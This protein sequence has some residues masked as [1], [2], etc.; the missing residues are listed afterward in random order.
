MQL[1]FAVCT[2]AFGAVTIQ[3]RLALK[4]SDASCSHNIMEAAVACSLLQ[5]LDGVVSAHS[6]TMLADY[7]ITTTMGAGHM[8]LHQYITTTQWDRR[9][10]NLWFVLQSVV[11][12]IAN[13]HSLCLAHLDLKAQNIIITV[14]GHTITSA[15]L[16]D[17]GSARFVGRSDEQPAHVRCTYHVAAPESLQPSATPSLSCDMYSLGALMHFYINKEHVINCKDVTCKKEA[18]LR[19]N[20]QGITVLPRRDNCP[21][22]LYNI[23]CWL[24][25]PDPTLRPSIQGM[26]IALCWVECACAS[27][28]MCCFPAELYKIFFTDPISLNYTIFTPRHDL[29]QQQREVALTHLY[30]SS[31]TFSAIPLAMSLCDRYEGTLTADTLDAAIHLAHSV[32]FPDLPLPSPTDTVLRAIRGVT[33]ALEFK[34]YSDTCEWVL[35]WSYNITSINWTLMWHALLSSPDTVQQVDYYLR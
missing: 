10:Q 15:Q 29:D 13:M 2:G 22:F 31:H 26:C 1:C 28:I 18:L 32:L 5:G 35:K 3:G 12:G 8:T 6:A 16:I 27:C 20:T 9:S 7:S 11:A 24:L 14:S 25:R 4:S 21:P 23:M 34:L 33:N 30:R 19:Y 17:F